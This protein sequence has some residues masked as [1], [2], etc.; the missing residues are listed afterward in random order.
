MA[1]RVQEVRTGVKVTSVLEIADGVEVTDGNGQVQLFDAVVIATHPG[2]AL[3][4]L[5]EP[6]AAQRDVLGAMPYSHNM[7]LLHT[8]E[9]VMPSSRHAR[10]SWNF[11]RSHGGAGRAVTYDLTRL[12]RLDT[13]THYFVTL[14]GEGLVDP[15]K[16]IDRMEY[17]HPLYNPARSPPRAQLAEHRHRADQLRRRLP[18]LGV[19]RGRRPLGAGGGDPARA[20]LARGAAP[21]ARRRRRTGIYETTIRHTRRTPFKRSFTH[22]LAD[23]GWWTSTTCPT[24]ACWRGSRVR[25]TWAT[26]N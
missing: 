8:D 25:T 3:A 24:T 16:V 11:G 18:R 22:A 10:A 6:T 2:Q 4:M 15:A 21:L 1:A 13:D 7:A 19:P 23:C 5:A 12:Q 20:S 14:G 9:S 17:E 26:R